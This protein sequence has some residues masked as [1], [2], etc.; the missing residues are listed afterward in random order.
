MDVEAWL[1]GLGLGQYARAFAENDID[2]STLPELTSDDLKELGVA[3]VGH[4]RKLLNAIASLAEPA[5]PG[6]A[7]T[8][9]VPD[10][11]GER[12]QVTVLFADL[13]GF[14][15]LSGELD[16]EELH[17][18]LGRYFQ[19]VDAIIEGYDGTIDKHIGDAVMALFGAPVAHGDDPQRAVRAAFDIHGAMARLSAEAGRRLDVH[20][21]IASGEV[22]A[23]SVGQDERAEYTVVGESVNLAARL[24]EQAGPGETLVSDAVWRAVSRMV[25]GEPLKQM[26]VKGFAKP[27]R[28][29][30]ARAISGAESEGATSPFIGRSA[31][32]LQFKSL[33]E[34]CADSE[35]GR[36][37][38]VRGEAGIGKTRLVE[39]CARIAEDKGFAV[40]KALVLDFGVGT[41]QD[42]IRSLV[43]SLLGLGRGGGEEQR[44]AAAD[45]VV[46]AGWLDPD[47]RVYLNDLLNLPQPLA[48]RSLYDAMDNAIRNRGKQKVVA[49]LIGAAS[50]QEP[51]FLTVE[52]L[53]WA[54]PLT[55]AH[56][57]V[58]VAAVHD[59]PAVLVISTRI[60]GDPLDS[61]W[62]SATGGAPLLTIDLGPL[63]EHE[64]MELASGLIDVTTATARDCIMRAEGNPLFLEQLVRA[65]DDSEPH[66]LPASLQSLVLARVD[67]LPPYDK[68]AVQAASVTGQRFTLDLLRHLVED[69]AYSCAALVQHHLL[70]LEG[71]D[72]LFAHALIREG[73][74]ASLLKARA[75]EWHRRTAQ[76]FADHDPVL[77][78]QHL[79]R[80]EDEGAAR[81]YL[82]A[83]R[84]QTAAYRFERARELVDR[85]LALARQHSDQFALTCLKGELLY[86]LGVIEESIGAYRNA[87]ELVGD[88]AE[89]CRTWIGLA[90]AL[91][92]S[93]NLGEALEALDNA[94]AAARAH[95]LPVDQARIHY[96]R[97]N[98]YFPLGRLEDCLGQHEEALRY[99]REAGSPECEALA[100]GGLG[101]ANYARGRMRTAR[102][103]FEQCVAL[104]R[105]HGFGH[106]EVA[107]QSMVGHTRRYLN[108]FREAVEDGLSAIKAASR[109]GQYRAELIGHRVAI[110]AKFDLG[111][112]ESVG[113][114]LER[115]KW[116]GQR[117]GA[118]RFEPTNLMY[119]ARILL[120]HGQRSEATRLL[121]RA[122][123]VSD[124]T[125]LRFTGPWLFGAFALATDDPERQRK[126]LEEGE[127][128]LRSGCVS[129]SHFFF[130][131]DAIETS[132]NAGN[133]E[134][135]ERY[136]DALGNYT[137]AEPLPF[138]DLLIARGRVLAAVHRG[139]QNNSAKK[140]LR[141]ISEQVKSIGLK[142]LLPAIEAA[143]TPS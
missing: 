69:P 6:P 19:T 106:I 61:T 109:V 37:M 60:E 126:A 15:R 57:A 83:A 115:L 129:H 113:E 43:R 128:L 7:E 131:G 41:G 134:A 50:K 1:S 67:R 96:Q 119:E 114:H 99:A 16:A 112:Y 140:E 104:S 53:H 91:R 17:D 49:N 11:T 45:R 94:E 58:M 8:R 44:A 5:A 2:A 122:I 110:D 48:L 9:S 92:V 118:K 36:A 73:I 71:E 105:T 137:R 132:I 81:A 26:T 21:G 22:V 101:D 68:L 3:S 10:L 38:L 85:G 14:T 79:D 75:R 74:Y 52:D 117:L 46:T 125:N 59:C 88:D 87:L 120:L 93:D 27:M 62:R 63:R 98:V 40:H 121:E 127:A 107:N 78:A 24:D 55:L 18:L 20:I 80:A 25:V 141:N 34:S 143:L 76:W 103:Y 135:A 56:L 65:V 116:L 13:C 124:E 89:R 108:E 95:D 130:Y 54:D 33:I 35:Q 23:A 28:V 64:A 4:R 12:R 138:S 142:P 66:T 123:S 139:T 133:W 111:R 136:A 47:H 70:R 86:D 31:E 90:A 39:E 77:H 42:A 30:R 100:L 82:E 32:L 72:Y 51:L 97:G 29:W 84:S 102:R